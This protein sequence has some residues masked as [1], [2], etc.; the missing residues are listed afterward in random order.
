VAANPVIIGS[1]MSMVTMS[2][3]TLLQISIACFPSWASPTS[4]ICGSPARIS[5]R[6]WRTV[7]ESSTTSTRILS[8]G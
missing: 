4:S 2:G 5:R 3:R 7:S 8:I 1:I 6:R